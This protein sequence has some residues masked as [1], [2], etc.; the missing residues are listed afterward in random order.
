[1]S[2]DLGWNDLIPFMDLMQANTPEMEPYAYL[3]NWWFSLIMFF[4]LAAILIALILRPLTR[5]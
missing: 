4:G 5:S 1:M 3:F 2:F